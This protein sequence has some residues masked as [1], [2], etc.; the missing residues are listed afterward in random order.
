MPAVHSS[1]KHAD[2][3]FEYRQPNKHNGSSK[4]KTKTNKQHLSLNLQFLCTV[5]LVL[6]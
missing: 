4:L 5:Q 2:D 3:P 1:K 6:E